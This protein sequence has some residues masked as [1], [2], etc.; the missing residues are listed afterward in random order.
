LDRLDG[1]TSEKSRDPADV[2]LD[3]E[4]RKH[5]PWLL[6]IGDLL[7]PPACAEASG[8]DLT[9]AFNAERRA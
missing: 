5:L 4:D 8:H 3:P 7:R 1:A 6:R 2:A 9:I